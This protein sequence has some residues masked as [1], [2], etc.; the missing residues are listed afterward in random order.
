MTASHVIRKQRIKTL[1]YALLG[2]ASYLSGVTWLRNFRN[3]DPSLRV[4]IYYKVNSVPGNILS[5]PPQTLSRQL[6]F[7]KEHYTVISPQ[8][9]TNFMTNGG[10]LPNRAVLLTFDD[11][12]QDVYENA[13]PLLKE[14]GLKALIFPATDYI[15]NTIRF[16]HDE[17]LP[18]SNP[19]LDWTQLRCMQD[20]F[21]VGSHTQSH[22]VLTTLPLSVAKE[23]IFASKKILEDRLDCAVQFFCY[24][25]GA[26]GQFSQSLE[27]LVQAA[28]YIGSFV[29][30]TGPNRI[31]DVRQGK[32]LRRY[33]AEPFDGFM[34][35]RLLDGSCDA[36]RFKDTRWGSSA[37]YTFNRLIGTVT[38]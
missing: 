1:V 13:Y 21:T 9:L 26:A 25:K 16:P 15:G 27:D 29:T 14:M 3:T 33:H 30:L 17:N 2:S 7:L 20:V 36:I 12:Y 19:A 34:F 35:A 23:E 5:T 28:G 31:E 8:Q 18:M 6:H 32:W 22:R 11:G 24:P 4:L 10:L 38:R 37:R